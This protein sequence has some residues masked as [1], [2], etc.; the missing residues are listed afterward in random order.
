MNFSQV[1]KNALSFPFTDIKKFLKVFILYVGCF[2]IIPGL[3]ALGYSLRVIQSTIVGLDELPDFDDSGKL[4]SDGLN[5]VGASIIYGI[6]SYIIILIIIFSGI[7]DFST[8]LLFIMVF[9]IV[10]FVINIVFLLALANMAFEDKFRAV[11]DFKKVFS[12]IKKI[13]LGTYLSYL[14]VYTIIVQVLSLVITFTNTYL[15]AVIGFIGGFALYLLIYF[16]FNTFMILFGGRFR[17]LIYLKGIEDQ[18]VME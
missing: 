2:L 7:H 1:F 18:D 16:L 13:G 14:V 4:I 15:I 17:G 8:N 3:M 11:F 9:A 6:P 10:G 12:I 5:Y